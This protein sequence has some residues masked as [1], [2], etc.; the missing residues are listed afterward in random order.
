[1]DSDQV[2]QFLRNRIALYGP[3]AFVPPAGELRPIVEL[4]IESPAAS[5]AEP[6]VEPLVETLV[7]STRPTKTKP[8]TTVNEDAKMFPVPSAAAKTPPPVVATVN[9]AWAAAGDLASLNEMICSCLKCPL[10]N[11]R[12]KFVFGVGDPKA[13][14]V[15]IGEAPGKDEDEQGEPF[16]GRAGQLLNKIL[17]AINFK[18]EE[19]FIC[20]ILKCRPPG[21]RDPLPAEVAQ[22]E[23]YLHKQLDILQPHLILALGRIAA[24][25]LLKTNLTMRDLRASTHDYRGIPMVATYHPAALLRNPNWKR[26]T[27]EDVKKLR[28]MYDALNAS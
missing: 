1:M 7:K 11:T 16:V 22:C 24:N 15:V 9:E 20:N 25:T 10:G 17:E 2:K 27:W 4:T 23:P 3:T 26:D 6:A 14:L 21:N 18:R 8:P 28:E 13:K 19:V 12:T 5:V